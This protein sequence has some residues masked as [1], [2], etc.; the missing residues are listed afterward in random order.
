MMQRP[1]Q[2]NTTTWEIFSIEMNSSTAF[3][4]GSKNILFLTSVDVA[5]GRARPEGYWKFVMRKRF[6]ERTKSNTESKTE[7]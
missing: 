1:D 7:L 4:L 2:G 3:S 6:S 5:R